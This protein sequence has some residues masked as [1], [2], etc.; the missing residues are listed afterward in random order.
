MPVNIFINSV[1]C[2]FAR[3]LAADKYDRSGLHGAQAGVGLDLNTAQSS[4]NKGSGSVG[5]PIVPQGSVTAGLGG[6]RKQDLNADTHI[7]FVVFLDGYDADICQ[8]G[9]ADIEDAFSVW[10]VGVVAQL[11]S[12]VAGR[13]KVAVK[14]YKYDRTFIITD[15]ANGSLKVIFGPGTLKA[16]LTDVSSATQKIH[17]EINAVSYI[18]GHKRKTSRP[19]VDNPDI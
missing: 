13:P 10:I 2:S 16:D 4:E 18:G 17:V 1:K 12:A 5:I 9:N 19:F 6:G 11:N 15:S 3:A 14:D 7:G 8:K